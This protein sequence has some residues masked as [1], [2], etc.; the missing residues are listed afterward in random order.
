MT[1]L[2]FLPTAAT[3]RARARIKMG[4]AVAAL[5]RNDHMKWRELRDVARKLDAQAD[6]ARAVDDEHRRTLLA[7]ERILAR[8]EADQSA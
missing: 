4:E 2:R 5:G 8:A 7:L 1:A 6:H 3:L